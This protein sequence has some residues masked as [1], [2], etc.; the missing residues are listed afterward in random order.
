MFE[1]FNVMYVTF[2]AD[3]RTVI[4]AA[5]FGG[6]LTLDG[7]NRCGSSPDDL[8]LWR[9]LKVS[10]VANDMSLLRPLKFAI[11]FSFNSLNFRWNEK[12]THYTNGLGADR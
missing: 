2:G 1:C 11:P 6:N 5:L 3:L 4:V 9:P 10:L 12:S 8:S 7:T